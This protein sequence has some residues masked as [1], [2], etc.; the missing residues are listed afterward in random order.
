M[1]LLDAD[2]VMS[3]TA[4]MLLRFLPVGPRIMADR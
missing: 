4:V 2:F 1:P 3:D